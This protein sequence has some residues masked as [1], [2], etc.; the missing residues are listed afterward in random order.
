VVSLNAV[1]KFPT[2]TLKTAPEKPS[3]LPALVISSAVRLFGSVSI[4]YRLFTESFPDVNPGMG[5]LSPLVN[6]L[7]VDK[8]HKFHSDRC[9]G[10]IPYRLRWDMRG[11]LAGRP[12]PLGYLINGYVFELAFY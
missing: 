4:H 11:V 12:Q 5:L 7:G 10:I 1:V 8:I 6:I 3:V 2:F 9:R